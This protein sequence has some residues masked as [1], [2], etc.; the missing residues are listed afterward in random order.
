ME[1]RI[2]HRQP[3]RVHPASGLGIGREPPPVGCRLPGIFQVA[4]Q[5]IAV[6]VRVDE[7][8]AGVVRGIDVDGGD[9]LVVG[10]L[11][12][13]EHLQVLAFD[14]DVPRRVRGLVAVRGQEGAQAPLLEQLQAVAPARPAHP[15]PLAL[16]LAPP[17]L[18][19]EVAD[20]VEI[21]ARPFPQRLGEQADQLR[22]QPPEVI[23]GTRVHLRSV[24]FAGRGGDRRR[25]SCAAPGV[26]RRSGRWSR[27]GCQ[28]RHPGS[29]R[30]G[31]AIARC[32]DAARV[33]EARARRLVVIG[34]PRQQRAQVGIT[35][36]L[37]ARPQRREEVAVPGGILRRAGHGSSAPGS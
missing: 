33:E 34:G 37:P 6:V 29:D 4:G 28:G 10:V 22:A 35:R 20:L 2:H 14:E 21:Y 27:T 17:P 24:R 5:A 19:E 26:R 36:T 3:P 11:E 32:V 30:L 1:T 13:A 23:E 12:E 31:H 15:V 9:A 25:A 16:R 18:A 7:L 8:L